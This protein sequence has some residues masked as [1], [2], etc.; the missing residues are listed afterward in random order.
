MPVTPSYYASHQWL[1]ELKRGGE[2]TL[3]GIHFRLAGDEPVWV[4]HYGHAHLELPVGRAIRLFLQQADPLGY[5][6]L[7]P[8]RIEPGEIVA[9]RTVPQ[10]VGW[11]YHPGAH[12][13]RPTCACPFCL[14][15]GSIKSRKL[16][17][18][19]AP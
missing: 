4:G 11:R 9:V 10:V 6:F 19:L 3:V 15:P 14:P 18:R 12:G 7:V 17:A 1:R 13:Q 8:R 5:E 2:R 16:R